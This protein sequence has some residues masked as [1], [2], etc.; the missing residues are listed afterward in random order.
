MEAGRRLFPAHGALTIKSRASP[1]PRRPERR[2]GIVEAIGH[3]AVWAVGWRH[4]LLDHLVSAQHYR[5]GYGK[6]ERS[7]G[8]AVHDHLE[9]GRKLNG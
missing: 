5:W 9:L 6:A 2:L 8:L 1:L 3:A 4:A 7:G